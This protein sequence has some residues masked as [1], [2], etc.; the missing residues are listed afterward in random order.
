[1]IKTLY[2]SNGIYGKLSVHRP[3]QPDND[4]IRDAQWSSGSGEV[5]PAIAALTSDDP[6]TEF[7][8]LQRGR[9]DV[10]RQLRAF[11]G[12]VQARPGPLL[13]ELVCQHTLRLHPNAPKFV[14]AMQQVEQTAA[15]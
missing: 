15:E 9:R 14:A 2:R 1:M 3:K 13:T 8:K 5:L 11:L 7:Y 12:H 10:L 4:R 6:A